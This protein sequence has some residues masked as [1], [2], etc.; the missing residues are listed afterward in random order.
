MSALKRIIK[1]YKEILDENN[2]LITKVCLETQES[3]TSSGDINVDY[4]YFK[5]LVSF[6][7]PTDSLYEN[8]VF[9]VQLDFT[10]EYP[11]KPPNCKMITKTFHPNIS[12]QSICLNALQNEWTPAY[13]ITKLILAISC[14]LNEPNFDDP[15]NKEAATL[16]KTNK[17]EYKNTVLYYVNMF[18]K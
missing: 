10:K 13:T 3:L 7:G 16:Y 2:S 6:K 14:I 9:L 18:A 4:N 1:D 17:E 15:L 8:G 11:Y 12:N 5:W